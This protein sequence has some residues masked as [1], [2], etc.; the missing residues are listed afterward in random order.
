MCVCVCVHTVKMRIRGFDC[1]NF[2]MGCTAI[3]G[4]WLSSSL[5]VRCDGGA[6]MHFKNQR[7]FCAECE[8]WCSIYDVLWNSTTIYNNN[9]LFLFHVTFAGLR[10][11]SNNE[12]NGENANR[13]SI[14]THDS[15]QIKKIIDENFAIFIIYF[16]VA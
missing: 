7:Y 15:N 11:C 2:K 12:S 5:C 14:P 10:V 13:H 6:N 16:G 8:N 9:I 1:E 3:D 4:W